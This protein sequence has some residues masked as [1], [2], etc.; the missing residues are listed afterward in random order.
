M[1]T[2]VLATRNA[3]KLREFQALI[4]DDDAL[5]AIQVVNVSEFTGV[6]DVIESGVTFEQNAALKACAVCEATGLPAIA[7]DSGLCV[8]VL[9]G[10]PGVFSAR[11]AGVHG[12]DQDNIDLLLAQTGDVDIPMAAQFVCC[13]VLALPG[14][15]VHTRRGEL[16]GTITREQRG[17]DGF[18]YDPIFELPD[19]RTL[20]ELPAAEKN[21]ISHRAI[22]MRAMRVEMTD[23]L[24]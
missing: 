2:V 17:A 8:D 16:H 24:T 21:Q 22:A 12:A 5:A 13:V 6:Q 7:D 14:G 19:G 11:W 20:A 15:E 9:G 18:G 10:S 23:V 4:A 1:T 3:G